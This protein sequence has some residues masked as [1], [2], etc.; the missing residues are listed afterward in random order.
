MVKN[1]PVMRETWFDPSLEKI[2]W[3]RRQLPTPV[4]WPGAFH[5]Q[6]SLA[7]HRESVKTERI[8]LFTFIV[9]FAERFMFWILKCPKH[10]SVGICSLGLVCT[11]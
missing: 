11:Y 1:P 7:G 3:R 8:S 6:K 10:K 9:S 2:P 4:F 5:G